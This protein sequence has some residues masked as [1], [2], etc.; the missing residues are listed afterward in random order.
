MVLFGCARCLSFVPACACVCKGDGDLMLQ[1]DICREILMQDHRNSNYTATS[2]A[3]FKSKRNCVQRH[4][5][6]S[7]AETIA[8]FIL[9]DQ[10]VTRQYSSETLGGSVVG[11]IARLIVPRAHLPAFLQKIQALQ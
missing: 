6:A 5:Y 9:L 8:R 1:S 11:L 4:K 3:H 7:Y 2:R 10:R